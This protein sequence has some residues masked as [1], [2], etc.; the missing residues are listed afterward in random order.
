MRLTEPQH[1]F[2][3]AIRHDRTVFKYRD[4][5]LAGRRPDDAEKIEFLADLI[6][7]LIASLAVPALGVGLGGLPWGVVRPIVLDW[8]RRLRADCVVRLYW[9]GSERRRN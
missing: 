5:A 4:G 3:D 1:E 2:L 6:A 7:G 9:P 8:A